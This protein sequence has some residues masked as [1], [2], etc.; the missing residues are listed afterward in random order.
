MLHLKLL[1]F[2]NLWIELQLWEWVW[3]A[4]KLELKG[5]YVV[6]VDV[7]VAEGVDELPSFKTTNLCEH[8]SE[9]GIGSDV[10]GD[11]E[12]HVAGSLVHLATQSRLLVTSDI[13]LSQNMARW[14]SHVL[15]SRRIPSCHYD[16]SACWVLLYGIDHLSQLINTH[17][18]IA[19][20]HGLILGAKVSPLESVNGTKVPF[21]SFF[22]AN[23]IQKLSGSISIPD[24][25]LF[26]AQ[27]FGIRLPIDKPKELLSQSPPKD[28]FGGQNWEA[29]TQIKSHLITEFGNDSGASAV[30]F[31]LPGLNYII[32]NF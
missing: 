23:L 10:E 2:L 8:A 4:G 11:A 24:S 26:I 28:V 21:F 13:E 31:E 17:T 19:R 1:N 25:D 27:D 18:S 16:S 14:Q 6:A 32:N 30:V 3:H 9:Q 5:L 12:A 7:G 20:M 29:L 22:E 15:K